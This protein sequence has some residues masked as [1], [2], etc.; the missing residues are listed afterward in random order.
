MLLFQQ[1]T[2]QR[3]GNPIL[4]PV[5]EENTREYYKHI[6]ILRGYK[7]WT[8]Y[9]ESSTAFSN[10]QNKSFRK[11]LCKKILILISCLVLVV[12]LWYLDV[13]CT[14]SMARITLKLVMAYGDGGI[15]ATGYT[16]THYTHTQ[17]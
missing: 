17:A 12:R 10:K 13:V 8:E 14:A 5:P 11:Y 4:E 6:L 16:D 2:S 15:R 7:H 1:S 9:G 3:N